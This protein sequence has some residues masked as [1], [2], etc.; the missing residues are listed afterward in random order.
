MEFTTK[1]AW[2][3]CYVVLSLSTSYTP[4]YV[5]PDENQ[6]SVFFEKIGLKWVLT[7]SSMINDE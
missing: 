5:K 3:T 7:K 2:H 6:K 4:V 1:M